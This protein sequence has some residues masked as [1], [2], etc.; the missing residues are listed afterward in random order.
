MKHLPLIVACLFFLTA[1][2]CNTDEREK[3]LEQKA[4]DLNRLE[5]ELELKRQ[6]LAQ[7]EEE[8]IQRERLIDST[9]AKISYDTLAVLHPNLPG[10]Y[11]VI[12]KCT[13]ATCPGY[14]VGDTKS[15]QWELEFGNNQVMIKAMSDKKLVRIYKG[16]Y[17]AGSM[18]L[19]AQAD[20]GSTVQAGNMT[21]RLQEIK[22]NQLR[23]LREITRQ[24][25]CRIVYEL[26]LQKQ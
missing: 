11:N 9:S 18:E 21:V 26:D 14:A 25:N 4:I 6:S 2:S 1:F 15:E 3:N 23:G 22:Q 10:M 13:E 12:M 19:F 17:T 7:K 20:T 24:D 8:L 16:S 5:Q